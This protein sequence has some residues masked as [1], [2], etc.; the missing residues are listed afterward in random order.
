[1]RLGE[2]QP[3]SGSSREEKQLGAVGSSRREEK[4]GPNTLP[5]EEEK[6]GYG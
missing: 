2:N 4:V 6:K 1:M 3:E 5:G